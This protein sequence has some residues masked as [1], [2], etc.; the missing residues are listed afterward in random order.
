MPFQIPNISIQDIKKNLP[1]VVIMLLICSNIY[2]MNVS[3]S[4]S[5]ACDERMDKLNASND[6]KDAKYFDA[7]MVIKGYKELVG[8]QYEALYKRDS[9]LRIKTAKTATQIIN[10]KK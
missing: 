8:N 10:T 1:S 7:L 3:T 2:Y 6:L 5:R 4:N 9:I